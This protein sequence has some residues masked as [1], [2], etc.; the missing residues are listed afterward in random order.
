LVVDFPFSYYE[1]A[2]GYIAHVPRDLSKWAALLRPYKL[3][4]FVCFT[5]FVTFTNSVI[6]SN[7]L[8]KQRVLSFKRRTVDTG[9]CP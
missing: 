6:S 4:F 5:L 9:S 7:V 8:E 3:R 1:T 2:S